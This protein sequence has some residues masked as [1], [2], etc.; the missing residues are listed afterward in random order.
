MPSPAEIAAIE[1]RLQEMPE[2]ALDDPDNPEWTEADVARAKGPESL[3]EAELAAFPKTQVNRG[4]RP[5][6]IRPKPA[7]NLRLDAGVL[8]HLR[9]TG[10]GWQTRVNNALASLIK[11]G[12]L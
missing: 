4:G 9:S 1:A 2:P 12:R 3:S 10:P 11:Q 5:R 6:A 7:V 8:D